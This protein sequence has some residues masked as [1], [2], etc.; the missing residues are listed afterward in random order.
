MADY[1]VAVLDLADDV[2]RVTVARSE[3]GVRHAD[4]RYQRGVRRLV[5]SVGL[6]ADDRRG[7]AAVGEAL[8]DALV[9]VIDAA[10]GRPLLLVDAV[11]GPRRGRRA[12]RRH[13]VRA[14]M[15]AGAH[16]P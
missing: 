3:R 6:R 7:L 10:G 9:E 2:V 1:V 16:F 12:D 14:D 11:P 4:Q 13:H 8:E 5:V 15:G